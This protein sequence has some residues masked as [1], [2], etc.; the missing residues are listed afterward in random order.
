MLIF[1]VTKHLLTLL[2]LE[3]TCGCACVCA[4]VNACYMQSQ[5]LLALTLIGQNLYLNYL[6]LFCSGSEIRT[7]S[8]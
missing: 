2:K 6:F 8:A 3:K 4:C 5:W 1:L 7:D